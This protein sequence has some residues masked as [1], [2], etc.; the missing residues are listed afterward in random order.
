[1]GCPGR[2]VGG[3]DPRYPIDA[4]VYDWAVHRTPSFIGGFSS[5]RQ[6]RRYYSGGALTSC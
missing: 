3:A 2:H 4:G 1:V 6:E 5:S